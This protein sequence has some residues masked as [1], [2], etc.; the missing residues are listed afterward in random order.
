MSI[1]ALKPTPP[2]NPPDPVVSRTAAYAAQLRAMG[3]DPDALDE[4]TD[5]T[6][7]EAEAWLEGR[8]PCP[9]P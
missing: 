6:L 1:P 3:A 2:P 9:V 7:E 5:V 8:A 4:G